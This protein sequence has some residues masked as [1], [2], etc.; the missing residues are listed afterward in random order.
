MY[1]LSVEQTKSV[2]Y[3]EI[4]ESARTLIDN[5]KL[6]CPVNLDSILEKRNIILIKEQLDQDEAMLMKEGDKKIIIVDPR[7]SNGQ[8][9][10]NVG[11]EIGHDVRKHEGNIFTSP[12][13]AKF[14]GRK[15][16]EDLEADVF[17]SELLIPTPALSR[18]AAYCKYDLIKMSNFFMVSVDAM[19]FKLK[20]KNMP[21]R[22]KGKIYGNF[23]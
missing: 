4:E 15:S 6:A 9:R 7:Q 18:L 19:K 17:A 22:Y 13:G 12:K 3:D 14:T 2:N 23:F 21:Y 5:Y 1:L 20:V 8:I 11:H 16:I 10:F